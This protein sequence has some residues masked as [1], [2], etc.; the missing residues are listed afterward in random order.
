VITNMLH[1]HL[2][3]ITAASHLL[4]DNL[5]AKNTPEPTNAVFAK[6]HILAKSSSD[7]SFGHSVRDK[8]MVLQLVL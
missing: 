5:L 6:V 4:P 8:E 1:P 7:F 3:R 2:S